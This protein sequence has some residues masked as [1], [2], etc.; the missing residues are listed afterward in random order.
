MTAAT[1]RPTAAG[2][3]G[4]AYVTNFRNND[5]QVI[6]EA[7]VPAGFYDILLGY[8]SASGPKGYSLQAGDLEL[9]GMF[10]KTGEEFAVHRAG[11]AELPAGKNAITLKKGWGYY[12]VDYLELVKTNPPKPPDRRR[13]AHWP[14][15]G[16]CPDA[17][18][19]SY[20]TD[21]TGAS[22][23][24]AS[25]PLKMPSTSRRSTGMYPAIMGGDLMDYSPSPGRPRRQCHAAPWRN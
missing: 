12:D 20:L 10:D 3:S 2:P 4:G 15:P 8:R 14:I 5:D 9:S 7:D 19:D 6:S 23:S 24:R 1:T 11:L 21:V 16:I 18:T 22:P 17:A 25:T 13:R